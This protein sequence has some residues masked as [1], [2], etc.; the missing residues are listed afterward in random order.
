MLW[1]AR[2]FFL[3]SAEWLLYFPKFSFWL[4]LEKANLTCVFKAH[5]QTVFN[6]YTFGLNDLD[7]ISRDTHT[8]CACILHRFS[9]S[10]S[11]VEYLCL[12]YLQNFRLAQL[13]KQSFL[14]FIG[15]LDAVIFF[16]HLPFVSLSLFLRSRNYCAA[17]ITLTHI[18]KKTPFFNSYSFFIYTTAP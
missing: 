14:L 16:L 11:W 10:S 9:L 4:Y 3:L 13:L 1:P 15:L 17:I 12:L 6:S 2:L 7:I 18:Q 5:M 8:R